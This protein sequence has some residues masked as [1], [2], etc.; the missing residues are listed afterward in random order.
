MSLSDFLVVRDHPSS[1]TIYCNVDE[2]L[3]LLLKDRIRLTRGELQSPGLKFIF[4]RGKNWTNLILTDIPSFY[5]V[6]EKFIQVLKEN[7][8]TGWKAIDI[9]LYGKDRKQILGYLGLVITGRCGDIDDSK[10]KCELRYGPSGGGYFEK[11]GYYFEESSWD[12]SDLFCP[13]DRG[14]I[15]TSKRFEEVLLATKVSNIILVNITKIQRI[16]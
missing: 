12:H 9:E 14:T 13:G 5:L 8:I 3:H 11:T 16:G 2:S 7:S 10:I 4:S 6:T 15:F 1:N